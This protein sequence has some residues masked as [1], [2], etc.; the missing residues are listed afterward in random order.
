MP[1]MCT[2]RLPPKQYI[3]RKY[4]NLTRDWKWDLQSCKFHLHV[5]ISLF[6]IIYKLFKG[7]MERSESLC[8]LSVGEV[9]ALISSRRNYIELRIKNIDSVYNTI[10]IR[11]SE[12]C[13]ALI[14]TNRVLPGTKAAVS[15]DNLRCKL[16]A[17][18]Y[19]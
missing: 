2:N 11:E 13:M 7:F 19:A 3:H 12:S 9:Y 14:L 16:V 6:R 8:L 17:L 5:L 4:N 10:Q 1:T 15:H 18:L